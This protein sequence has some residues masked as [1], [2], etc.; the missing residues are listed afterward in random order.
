MEGG[1]VARAMFVSN[2]L[3]AS[4]T[5][6]SRVQDFLSWSFI[7]EVVSRGDRG[8]TT[9]WKFEVLVVASSVLFD[10][11]KRRKGA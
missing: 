7:Y 1:R 4:H 2:L 9:P 11:K 8:N 6:K 3:S 10:L 5:H